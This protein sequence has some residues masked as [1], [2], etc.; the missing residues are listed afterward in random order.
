MDTQTSV[1]EIPSG[2]EVTL[3]KVVLRVVALSPGIVRFRYA[4]NGTFGPDESFAVVK[5][6]GFSRRR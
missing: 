3:G 5:D 1:K 2:M 6:T 4:P